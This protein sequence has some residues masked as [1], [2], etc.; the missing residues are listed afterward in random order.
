MSQVDII[1]V[2]YVRIVFSPNYNYETEN[3]GILRDHFGG[4]RFDYDC[5]HSDHFGGYR[6]DS[7]CRHLFR[8]QVA[9]RYFGLDILGTPLLRYHSEVNQKIQT[10]N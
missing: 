2:I 7:D 8:L 4:Y 6:F 9:F 5:R 1:A 3:I 10:I